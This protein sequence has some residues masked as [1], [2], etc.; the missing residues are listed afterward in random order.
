VSAKYFLSIGK[1]LTVNL[2]DH[3]HSLSVLSDTPS[4]H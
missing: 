2:V 1:E 4:F 3:S